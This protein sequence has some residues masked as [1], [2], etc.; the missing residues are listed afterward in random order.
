MSFIEEQLFAFLHASLSCQIVAT[1]LK[2][3]MA[4]IDHCM[5]GLRVLFLCSHDIGRENNVD[6]LCQGLIFV[7]DS[8]D[9]ERITEAQEELQKMVSGHLVIV[10]GK[11]SIIRFAI[12]YL[13][14]VNII[15]Y[16]ISEL[17]WCIVTRRR[18]AGGNFVSVCQQARL[19]QCNDRLRAH[20][21]VG[22][23]E[24]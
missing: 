19:A 14:I 15:K 23:P 18:A 6:I 2:P 22:T 13:N 21:Q 1:C 7:V 5:A 10:I 8:N 11:L 24:P 17:I 9:R 16:A 12:G 20:R 4:L 3:E